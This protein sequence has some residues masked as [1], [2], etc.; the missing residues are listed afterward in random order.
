MPWPSVYMSESRAAMTRARLVSRRLVPTEWLPGAAGPTRVVPAAV[1]AGCMGRREDRACLPDQ[2]LR[3]PVRKGQ[4]AEGPDQCG[5]TEGD[6]EPQLLV[7]R[8]S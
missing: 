3:Q 1:C 5:G 2:V 4:A 7:T 6:R 8:R